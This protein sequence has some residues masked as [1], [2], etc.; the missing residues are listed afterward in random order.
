[1]STLKLRL[2]AKIY[3]Y[4]GIYLAKNDEPTRFRDKVG[5]LPLADIERGIWHVTHGFH[6]PL[7]RIRHFRPL[8]VWRTACW[9]DELWS[10]I[11]YDL[12]LP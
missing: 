3:Q 6:R 1:M 8:W 7:S 10:Q 5:K 9:L 12:R 2:K 11:K 4:T